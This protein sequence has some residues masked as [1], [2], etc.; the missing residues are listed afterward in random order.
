MKQKALFHSFF[1]TLAFLLY[2][3]SLTSVIV[4]PDQ[5]IRPLF[6]LWAVLFVL[7]FPA[8]WLANSWD[9][10]GILLSVFVLGFFTSRAIFYA[11][12]LISL[13]GI[14]AWILVSLLRK[15]RI[16]VRQINLL[17]N[18]IS[19]LL[20]VI[21]A[22]FR[23]IVPLSAVPS[24]YYRDAFINSNHSLTATPLIPDTRP[25]VY[26]IV[27][28]GYGRS[29]VLQEL[30]NFDNTE[31][32]EY[33]SKKG[34]IVPENNHSNY[35]KTV[36]S[37]ASTLNMNYIQTI[38]PGLQDSFYWWLLSPLINHSK[39]RN[40][41]ELAGYKTVSIASDWSITNNP[42][43]D[44]YFKPYPVQLNDFEGFLL[45]S[46]PLGVLRSVLGN[47]AFIPSMDAHRQLV[48]YNFKT[49]SKIS[50]I[51]G[52]KFV[53][54]HIISP[55][56]PFVFN[57]AGMPLEPN[58]SFSFN[59]AN[60]FSGTHEQ[61]KEGYIGQVKFVNQ[62]LEQMIDAILESSD[63]PPIIILQGDHGPG[64]LTDF[65]SVED[66]CIKERF[67]PFAA[68]YLPG[69]DA[70]GVPS[71]I[72]PVNLFRIIF[73]HYFSTNFPMLKNEYYYFTDTV[74]I[75]RPV[76]VSSRINVSCN[77]NH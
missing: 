57:S 40:I 3:Y 23:V 29:D 32:V 18:F 33:L 48:S 13:V 10:A 47:F 64:M 12:G 11:F 49:L 20:V 53:F 68:Y 21:I 38:A 73:N 77:A 76:D 56:P 37:V 71:D 19:I 34:F 31:F 66:T 14:A 7:I 74:Y 75:Y 15:R 58:Y 52:P 26:Y 50:D 36:L 2:Q 8:H 69:L 16:L 1:F 55:H 61:Y 27:L 51:V 42:S 54:A 67:S 5:I 70:D 60:D 30:Y 6:V 63:T 9:W 45:A 65:R 17:L 35:P 44:Y 24:S 59:D 22:V 4:A 41:F 62:Q 28:D 39:V 43:V 25:D 46:T 72:T